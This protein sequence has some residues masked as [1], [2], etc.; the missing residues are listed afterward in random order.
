M[1]DGMTDRPDQIIDLTRRHL[2]AMIALRNRTQA[3]HHHMLPHVFSRD[4]NPN[5]IKEEL[6]GYLPPWWPFSSRD[7]FAR[8]W[9]EGGDLAGYVLFR[10][11]HRP[12]DGLFLDRRLVLINDIAVA[13]AHQD[14]GIARA[15]VQNVVDDAA[16]TGDEVELI[17]TIWEG[18]A[19]S[20]RVFA[21]QGFAPINT[22][23]SLVLNGTDTNGA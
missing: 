14:R 4:V 15:L 22:A 20:Q 8:G 19:A 21:D 5:L 3:V 18:N 1:H 6:K 10:M 9:V 2:T 12:P 17:A 23:F 11:G 16:E 13:Q 7:S